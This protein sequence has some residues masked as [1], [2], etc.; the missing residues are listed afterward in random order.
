MK[1]DRRTILKGMG[2]TLA[3]P[4]L[5]THLSA[6]KSAPPTRFLV[7]GNPFGAHPDFFFPKEFGKDFTMSPTLKSMEWLKDRMTVISHTDHNMVS[8]SS[9]V[10][11]KI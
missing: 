6:A 3:L 11:V 7:V 1:T 10:E 8:P 2:G 4:F 5:D 9:A